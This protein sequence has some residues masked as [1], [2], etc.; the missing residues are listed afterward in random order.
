MSIVVPHS[1]ELTPSEVSGNHTF[2]IEVS[3][4][5][6]PNSRD[7]H[8][9]ITKPY[10]YAIFVGS[11]NNGNY[12]RGLVGDG[13]QWIHTIKD[14]QNYVDGVWHVFGF[15]FHGNSESKLYADGSLVETASPQNDMS[16]TTNDLYFGED[17]NSAFGILDG[18]YGSIDEI[19]L[20]DY[21][22]SE[23]EFNDQKFVSLSGDETDLLG[24]WPMEEGDGSTIEDFTE[25]NNNGTR[26]DGEWIQRSPDLDGFFGSPNANPDVALSPPK[27]SEVTGTDAY[28]GSDGTLRA[29]AE[30]EV[31]PLPRL[32]KFQRVLYRRANAS[33]E[34]NVAED[35][36]N[37]DNTRTVDV[38]DLSN[39]VEYEFATKAFS[40]ANTPTEI[41]MASNSPVSMAEK[42]ESP[43]DIQSFTA[44]TYDD[45]AKFIWDEALDTD[46]DHYS[47]RR[48][49]DGEGL[50]WEQMEEVYSQVEQP[51]V[52]PL[53]ISGYNYYIKAVDT[54]GN[55]SDNMAGLDTIY[56]ASELSGYDQSFTS[57]YQSD[58]PSDITTSAEGGFSVGISPDLSKV[59]LLAQNYVEGGYEYYVEQYNNNGHPLFDP[60]DRDTRITL[61][62]TPGT[63]G[64]I[65]FVN[66]GSAMHT[67]VCGF[68]GEFTIKRWSLGTDYRLTGGASITSTSVYSL[69]TDEQ[70][71]GFAWSKRG[72]KLFVLTGFTNPS[73]SDDPDP[74]LLE[75][76]ASNQFDESSLSL[77]QRLN[78]N[79]E[80]GIT[81]Y[82][83]GLDTN[84]ND[85][86]IFFGNDLNYYELAFGVSGDITTL[87]VNFSGELANGSLADQSDDAV[88]YDTKW[89]SGGT[90]CFV[91]SKIPT[92]NGSLV[93]AY[94]T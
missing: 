22:R 4:S 81:Q 6:E 19:R 88:I 35:V 50:T 39:D 59:F 1:S 25:N 60:D 26:N 80:F 31:P 76:N 77:D 53:T 16:G 56:D 2:S 93:R 69:M 27:P 13:N 33:G 14:G 62:S 10:E 58:T 57:D 5:L 52:L 28:N 63:R 41:V 30:V 94:S 18:M 8:A 9:L 73:G 24:Y 34:W 83:G 61:N 71:S 42:S 38:P 32:A 49:V 90:N 44:E 48:E 87:S 79:T 92:D 43:Q 29:F 51:I 45:G 66:D 21:V 67:M 82:V 78:L 65:S 70:A 84:E 23:T 47:I 12:L 11:G 68:Q 15:S 7:E 75:Y 17:P 36:S 3:A 20:W 85:S 46:I 91:L 55:E 89:F 64:G 54:S 37:P 72:N 74:Y 40:L 86:K